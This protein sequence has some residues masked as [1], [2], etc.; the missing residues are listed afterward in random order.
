MEHGT[1]Q[2]LNTLAERIVAVVISLLGFRSLLIGF[3]LIMIG[4][5]LIEIAEVPPHFLIGR[6]LWLL[7]FLPSFP[8]LRGRLETSSDSTGASMRST[9]S[10]TTG[11]RSGETASA[12]YTPFVPGAYPPAGY[13]LMLLNVSVIYL[14]MFY[15]RRGRYNGGKGGN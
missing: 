11:S 3:H 2:R 7:P 12:T 10:A 6:Y 14:Q 8:L 1:Y 9:G 15:R 4:W 13:E 5:H